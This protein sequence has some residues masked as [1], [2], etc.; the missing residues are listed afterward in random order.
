MHQADKSAKTNFLTYILTPL[1]WIYGAGA[2]LRNKIY[3]WGIKKSEQFDVPVVSVGN[4]TVGGTGKTPHVEYIVD[5]LASAYHVAVLSRGYK[6]KTKGFV[7]AGTNSTPDTIGDEPYQIYRKFGYKARVAVCENRAKGIR[8]LL[9]I[10][11]NINLIILDDAFQHRGV[12][13]KVNMLLIDYSR[14]VE[15]DHL[16]PLGRLRES[17][18]SRYRADIVI[19]T[20]VPDGKQPIDFRMYKKNLDLWDYQELFFSSIRYGE[21]EPVF[22][23]E[24]RFSLRMSDLRESDAVLLISGIAN[25]RPFIRHFKKYPCRARVAHFADHHDFTRSELEDIANRFDNLKGA[26]RLIITTEKDAVRLAHNPYFPEHL[27]PY[28]F[29]LPITVEILYGIDGPDLIGKLCAA[30]NATPPGIKQSS[31][32]ENQSED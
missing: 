30:I 27:K 1:S 22:E 19:V 18:M 6:R 15:N 13:P 28:I 14:P 25:P 2:Y 31:V 29:Y 12:Q 16:L 32:S 23:K 9:E 20:K 11:P 8:K 4:L 7:L 26:R 5:N 21:L 3:D 17:K 10:D 24:N